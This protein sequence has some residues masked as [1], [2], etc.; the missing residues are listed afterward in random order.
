MRKMKKRYLSSKKKNTLCMLTSHLFL[1]RCW[2]WSKRL[3]RSLF[4]WD[5]LLRIFNQGKKVT[6]ANYLWHSGSIFPCGILF[7]FEWGS[8]NEWIIIS[9]NSQ[10]PKLPDE[11]FEVWLEICFHSSMSFFQSKTRLVG[12]AGLFQHFTS[13]KCQW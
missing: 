3:K 11:L 1:N 2:L 13:W 6:V 12:K 4:C 9:N 7:L 5:F 10:L 8:F